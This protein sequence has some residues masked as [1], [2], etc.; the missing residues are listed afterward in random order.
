MIDT[1]E[2][3]FYNSG[4]FINDG[5]FNKSNNK[6]NLG[7]QLRKSEHS[8]ESQETKNLSMPSALLVHVGGSELAEGFRHSINSNIFT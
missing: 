4:E 5:R 6:L 7:L 1:K 8:V 3:F 2:N